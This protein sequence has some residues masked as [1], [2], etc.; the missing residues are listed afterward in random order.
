MLSTLALAALMQTANP[1]VATP[2]A[3]PPLEET[4]TRIE[5]ND[6]AL[7]WAFFEGCDPAGAEPL[8]HPDFRMLHDLAGMPSDSAQAMVEQS[9]EQC[10]ARLPGGR[11][12]GY[13]N[14]RLI[15]P[16]S[17]RVQMLGTW[18]ALEEGHH[19]FHELRQRPPGAYGAR[20]LGGPTWV[21]T[22]GARYIHMW[23]WMPQEGRYRLR[24]SLSVDHAPS[25]PY[26][27]R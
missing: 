22:G 25:P 15:V 14:R 26:P 6:A 1:S 27:P 3:I 18:G 11:N 2:Q 9:R 13:A 21:Q 16:G 7:F 20:D 5:R 17:R 8:L 10:A 24:E 23:Q 4:V 12:E 19:T